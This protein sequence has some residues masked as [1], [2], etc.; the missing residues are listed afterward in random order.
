MNLR[1]WDHPTSWDSSANFVGEKPKGYALYSRNR[2]SSILETINFE[3]FLRRLGGES[4]SVTIVRHRHWACG[5]IE[6]LML[7]EDAP[8]TL[9]ETAI[10][11]TKSLDAYAIL[12]E[13]LYTEA[14]LDSMRKHWDN[15]SMKDRIDYCKDARISIFAA[16]HSLPQ[17]VEC[18]W[19]DSDMFN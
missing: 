17:E 11:I 5:W 2:E 3:E 8:H 18:Q 1:K 15:L 13:E 12:N 14:Q 10:E 19:L 4:E 16:R 9:I 7:K 6:Y